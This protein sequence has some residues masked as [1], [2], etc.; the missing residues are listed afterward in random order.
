MKAIL[1]IILSF[2][3]SYTFSQDLQV[4]DGN[5]VVLFAQGL[6]TIETQQEMLA[7]EEELKQH[8]NITMVRL[9]FQT[10]RSLIF[11]QGISSLSEVEFK[12][13]FGDYAETVRC[14]QI[15]VNGIDQQ[16]HYPYPNCN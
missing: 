9:D 15:G 2:I 13:W 12:S 5:N 6:F 14:I 4:T 10:Q 16:Q 7:L 3:G 8:P 11:T 1:I